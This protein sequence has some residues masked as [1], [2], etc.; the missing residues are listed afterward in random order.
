MGS[1]DTEYLSAK[2]NFFIKREGKKSKR[3]GVLINPPEN[4]KVPEKKE[5]KIIE[6]YLREQRVLLE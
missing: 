5:K 1:E 4:S 3:I 6:D 2:L